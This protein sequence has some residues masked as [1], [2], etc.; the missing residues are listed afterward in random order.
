MELKDLRM[1]NYLQSI[2]PTLASQVSQ[3]HNITFETINSISK[4]FGN[5]TMHDMNHGLRVAAYMEQLA[6]GI[7]NKFE[8]RMHSFN[9]MELALMLISAILHDIGMVIREEDKQEIKNNNI[10]Y[11]DSL[12]FEGVMQVVGNNEDEAIKEIIRRTHAARIYEFID[13]N[14][15]GISIDKILLVDNNYS[16]AEDVALICKAHGEEH[17]YLN[18]L[19]TEC[20]KGIYTYNVRYIAAL[21]RIADYLDLDKQRTPMLWFSVME[22]SGYSKD[23][24]EK[25]FVIHNVS[26]L[27]DYIDG[28]SQIYFDGKSA[29]AKIHRKYLRYIDD[30]KI[31]LEN[32]D[33]LLNTKT[34]A[35]KYKFNICTKIDD[36]VQTE[37]FT[38]SDLRLTLDYSAITNLLMGRNIYG[39]CRLGLRELIQNAI[40]SCELMKEIGL[41]E[42]DVMVVE[43]SIVVSYSKQNGYVKIKD[44]GIGMTLDVVKKHFLNVGKSFY[45]SNDFLFENRTY[46]PIG[47]YGIGFLACFLLSD[48]VTVKTK[49]YSNHEINQIELEKNSEYVVT[50]SQETPNFFGTEIKLEY[51]KFFKVFKSED[52]LKRFLESFFY[53]KI[54]MSL[55][56][57]DTHDTVNIKNHCLET[58]SSF[59]ESINKNKYAYSI[60]EC[61]KYST[62]LDG[63][64]SIINLKKGYKPTKSLVEPANSYLYNNQSE[65]F[66]IITDASYIDNEK[67]RLITYANISKDDYL[68]IKSK[69]HRDAERFS[70]AVISFAE[71]QNQKIDLYIKPED[72]ENKF[73]DL[74]YLHNDED[75]IDSVSFIEKIFT[76]SNLVFHRELFS[77]L[78]NP[79]SVVFVHNKEKIYL[80][81]VG[82]DN[83]HNRR[84]GSEDKLYNYSSSLYY[85]GILV[86]NF[87]SFSFH[88]PYPI[89]ELRGHI[90]AKDSSIKLD[91]SRNSIIEGKRELKEELELIL[92]KSLKEQS[93]SK[94]LLDA[95]IDKIHN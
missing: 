15:G 28:K 57:D 89:Y 44:T 22:I 27:R 6:F 23:E 48:S 43:P 68:K 73:I 93:D 77:F 25:H 71:G 41:K 39:D 45:K 30:L 11:A 53:T 58:M 31:E 40:D 74:Y 82:I 34:T 4:S 75:E 94:S 76:N 59:L 47:Q 80:H 42:R 65:T 70:K 18:T 7:D 9:A 86:P 91:V 61:N 69:R 66:E 35:Q 95:L 67:L 88:L 62:L 78:Y 85:K 38:Y 12:T 26:K 24:W 5:F 79:S 49:H 72:F 92:L 1:Y 56:N 13:F 37:G 63:K 2:E 87:I 83:Y 51:D 81:L 3:V 33:E 46:K 29:N 10:K 19:R 90:F 55:V 32:T 17:N 50:T 16:Y 20:T 52:D 64:I 36:R 54:R 8:E 21:L 84:T 14:F 60:V